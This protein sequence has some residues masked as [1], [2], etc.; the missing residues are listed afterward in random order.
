MCPDRTGTVLDLTCFPSQTGCASRT[1]AKYDYNPA[2]AKQLLAAAGYP[3]GFEIDIYVSGNR[4]RPL[5]EATMGDLANVGIQ[6][7]LQMVAAAMVAGKTRKGELP[8]AFRTWG[9]ASV[10]DPSRSTGHFFTNGPEDTAQDP[11]VIE[12][13]KKAD[14]EVDLSKR[15]ALYDE[16]HQRIARNVYALP[17]W[18]YAYFYAMIDELQFQPTPDEIPHLYRATWK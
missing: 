10:N 11:Q 6:A 7:R 1:A 8:L 14:A 12:L 18:S 4:D 17:L 15:L 3:N 5:A 9:S 2:K 16:A 13:I